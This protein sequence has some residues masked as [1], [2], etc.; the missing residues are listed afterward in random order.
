[1]LHEKAGAKYVKRSGFPG[2]GKRRSGAGDRQAGVSP[3]HRPDLPH[4]KTFSTFLSALPAQ[5]FGV[6]ALS[7][8]TSSPCQ[9]KQT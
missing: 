7:P 6:A 1:M 4:A 3:E 5:P 2:S 9:P 8:R